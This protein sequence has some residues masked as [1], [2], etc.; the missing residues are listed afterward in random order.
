MIAIR[1]YKLNSPEWV[2][3]KFFDCWKRRA[4]QQILDYVQLSW[5]N[6]YDE[7]NRMLRRSLHTLADAEFIQVNANTGAVAVILVDIYIKSY[8]GI[9]ITRH[10]VKL[11]HEEGQWG[12]DPRSIVL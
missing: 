5:L 12:I 4:W 6:Q 1:D 11:I 10:S 8:K 2:V 7:P 3:A 9:N